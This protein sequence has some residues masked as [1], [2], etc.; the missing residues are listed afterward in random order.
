MVLNLS[1]SIVPDVA[2]STIP[3]ISAHNRVDTMIIHDVEVKGFD[4]IFGNDKFL[5][6]ISAVR[7]LVCVRCQSFGPNILHQG[8]TNPFVTVTLEPP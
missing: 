5:F 2:E 8:V 3:V 7:Q 4:P 1:Q 6:A